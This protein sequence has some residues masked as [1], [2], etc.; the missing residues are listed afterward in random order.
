MNIGTAKVG[1]NERYTADGK[2]IPHHMLDIVD[3]DV[4]YSV[5]RFQKEAA[6][7]VKDIH[8]RGKLPILV[9]EQ[10]YFNALVYDTNSA[11]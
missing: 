8:T 3:P 2:Y 9:E 4:D 7:V 5:G 11:Q 1:P 6:L 10:A